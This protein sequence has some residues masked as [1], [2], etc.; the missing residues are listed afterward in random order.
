M[1]LERFPVKNQ[2]QNSYPDSNAPLRI[3]YAVSNWNVY[4]SPQYNQDKP[5]TF[6]DPLELEL[7]VV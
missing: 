4:S 1:P 2:F 6:A 7:K 3:S 5:E